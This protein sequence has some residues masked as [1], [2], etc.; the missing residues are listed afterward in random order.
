[1]ALLERLTSVG[2]RFPGPVRRALKTTA[3]SMARRSFFQHN[4]HLATVP[5]ILYGLTP[6]STLTNVGDH[7][8]AIAIRKWLNR[9]WPERPVIEFDKLEATICLRELKRLVGPDDI[10]FLHSGGNMSDRALFSERA[11]RVIIE[12]FPNNP[13]VSLPQTISFS[14]TSLGWGEKE[15]TRRI[16]GNH[17]QLVVTARDSTSFQ[18]AL[19]MFPRAKV[20][21]L[22]DFVLSMSQI[23]PVETLQTEI[24]YILRQDEESYLKSERDELPARLGISGEIF[25]TETKT[26]IYRGEREEYLERTLRKISRYRA[27][28]TDRYHGLIFAHLCRK[29]TVVLPTI[30]HKLTSVQHWF[31]NYNSVAFAPSPEAVPKLLH[32]VI[33]NGSE[34]AMWNVE[35]FDPYAAQIKADLDNFALAGLTEPIENEECLK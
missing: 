21:A 10:I 20:H 28:V 25:D 7:A 22:P 6:P 12:S 31:R 16:Y 1:M 5:K 23:E 24:L 26:P 11:R 29:P 19:E 3:Q 4:S 32:E 9:H 27:V 8:Q 18:T 2:S 35:H 15:E 13:I 34:D 33:A 30:D 17:G 14:E